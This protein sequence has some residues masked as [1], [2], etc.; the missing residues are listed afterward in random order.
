MPQHNLQAGIG[1]SRARR[2]LATEIELLSGCNADG[3]AGCS[4]PG[5]SHMIFIEQSKFQGLP[6]PS[7]ATA[8]VL[9]ATGRL[10]VWSVISFVRDLD[11]GRSAARSC[12]PCLILHSEGGINFVCRCTGPLHHRVLSGLG[13]SHSQ[14][15]R[16]L[17]LPV[18]NY[19]S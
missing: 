11:A 2:R 3:V 19:C 13:H 4:W 5:R 6:V 8:A 12:R 17:I 16:M 7:Q 15:G 18:R 14:P 9:V 1:V 10:Q